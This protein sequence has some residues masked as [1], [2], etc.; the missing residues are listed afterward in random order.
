MG[1]LAA[2][3]LKGVW[4]APQAA[5]LLTLTIHGKEETV[6]GWFA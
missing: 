2:M 1:R 4:L 6:S 3:H 5:Q